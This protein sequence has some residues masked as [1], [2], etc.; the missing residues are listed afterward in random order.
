VLDAL[1]RAIDGSRYATAFRNQHPV[2]LA[3]ILQRRERAPSTNASLDSFGTARYKNHGACL[4]IAAVA[5]EGLARPAEQWVC[6][7]GPWNTIVETGRSL[8][9]DR[10]ALSYLATVSAGIR[11]TSER[12]SDCP[13]LLDHSRPL[14]RRVRHAR[15][16]ATAQN[17]WKIQFQSARSTVEKELV[18]LVAF[19]WAR[20]NVFTANLDEVE[21]LVSELDQSRWKRIVYDARRATGLAGPRGGIRAKEDL[22]I[23]VLPKNLSP[24]VAALIGQRIQATD[25]ICR[26]YLR[27]YDSD[28]SIV[29]ELLTEEALDSRHFGRDSWKPDLQQLRKCYE[30]GAAFEPYN[31]VL[32]HARR[33][34]PTSVPLETA[35]QITTAPSSFP[36]FLLAYA[37][38][39][40]RQ[41]VATS[42]VPVAIIADREKWFAVS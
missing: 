10:H 36:E 15:L 8:W 32:E 4:E 37:E 18:L 25:R 12:G 24:R 22:D 6:D 42:V 40:C 16:R 3:S 19:T 17:W 29:L 11:S 39:R 30:R 26:R 14:T 2:P 5:E 41:E 1:N 9:G 23:D 33:Q 34:D 13:D 27:S 28:D 20:L 7:L 21:T 35:K 38:E 31:F